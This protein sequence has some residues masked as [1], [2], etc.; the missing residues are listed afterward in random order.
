M[1]AAE[2][3]ER[4]GSGKVA[5]VF[6]AGP[7]VVKLYR[8]SDHRAAAFRE[9]ATLSVLAERDLPVPEVFSVRLYGGRWGVEMSRVAGPSFAEQMRAHHDLTPWLGAMA[10]L[11]A[12]VHSRPGRYMPSQRQ[13]LFADISAAS[14]LEEPLRRKLLAALAAM[15]DGDRLCHGDYHPFN[16][17]G[18]LQEHFLVDWLDASSGSPA[19]DVCRSFVLI[20]G[21]D[22]SLA[23]LYVETYVARTGM[24]LI[25]IRRW[26]PFIAAARLAEGVAAESKDLLALAAR[27]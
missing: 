25:E 10:D 18:S 7:H 17:L 22:S 15:P 11:Q 1:P 8:S 12:R 23:R 3:G 20:S 19:A 24:A 4:L 26:L 14:L 2:L 9:A 13:R 27:L 16:L 5:E 21:F 6:A